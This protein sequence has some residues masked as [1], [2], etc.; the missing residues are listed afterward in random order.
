MSVEL[1]GDIGSLDLSSACGKI[2][3]RLYDSLFRAQDGGAIA[4]GDELS[5]RLRNTSYVIANAVTLGIV[6]GEG[7]GEDGVLGDYLLRK[8]DSMVGTLSANYGF[9]AGVNNTRV[10]RTFKEDIPDDHGGIAGSIYGVEVNGR[11]NVGGGSFYMDGNQVLVY[12]NDALGLQ[13]DRIALSAREIVTEGSLQIGGHLVL[14]GEGI[15]FDGYRFYHSGNSNRD[16]VSWAMQDGTVA[17]NLRV[18]GTGTFGG[19]LESLYGVRLGAR[20][21][22]VLTVGEGLVSVTGALDVSTGIK[23]GSGFVLKSEGTD[24][25]FSSPAGRLILGGSD[26][27]HVRLNSAIYDVKDEYRLISPYGDGY[28]PNSLS[29]GHG[30]GNVLLETYRTSVDDAGV[31]VTK[32]LRLGGKT[33]VSIEGDNETLTLSSSF[34]YNEENS[35][36]RMTKKSIAVPLSLRHLASTSVYKPLNKTSNSLFLDSGADFVVLNKPVE[37]ISIGIRDTSTRMTDGYLFFTED[38][39]LRKTDGGIRIKGNVLFNDSMSSDGFSNGFSGSGWKVGRNEMTGNVFATF[40]ELTVRKKMRIYELEVQKMSS[41]N[42]S[43]WV[44]NT[45]AGD[46]V[47]RL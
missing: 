38:I 18:S 33:G 9:E 43:I 12:G 22:T 29:A 2:Y 35:S 20:G 41:L 10:M 46:R 26:T 15:D 16:T 1:N 37:A 30:L 13:A 32:R 42:G 28:F 14:S 8:G 6:G 40:D 17:G 25:V 36:G 5:V 44:S 4:E 23:L 45:C 7:G 11:L 39:Y 19:S 21:H 47:E 34:V 31:V 24:V 3:T 27:E